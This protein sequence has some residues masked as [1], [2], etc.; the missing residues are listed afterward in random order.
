[1]KRLDNQKSQGESRQNYLDKIFA[2]DSVWSELN[3]KRIVLESRVQIQRE[4]TFE[5]FSYEQT[6]ENIK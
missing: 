4:V 3:Q 2:Q 6:T 1:V 5:S